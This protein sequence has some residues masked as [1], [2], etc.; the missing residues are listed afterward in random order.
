M[1]KREKWECQIFSL[2]E[3]HTERFPKNVT[4]ICFLAS[5]CSRF[6]YFNCRRF[7]P[8]AT[9]GFCLLVV[10]REALTSSCWGSAVLRGHK[11][12]P[13]LLTQQCQSLS[14]NRSSLPLRHPA[15]T[16]ANVTDWWIYLHCQ[17]LI[18]I[19]LFLVLFQ[20]CMFWILFPPDLSP[21]MNHE[22]YN[23]KKRLNEKQR[24][25]LCYRSQ[26]GVKRRFL[27]LNNL[28]HA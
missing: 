5:F 20:A 12:D 13:S 15:G 10:K 2:N 7:Q 6:L 11:D 19:M 14:A 1:G 21:F 26:K 28:A 25:D 17:D 23:F 27:D 3:K 8:K 18:L 22:I 9:C 24:F 4:F 16:R